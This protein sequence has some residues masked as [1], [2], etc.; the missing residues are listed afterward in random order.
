MTFSHAEDTVSV[1]RGI[2]F[3]PA[4]E[5]TA[6]ALH[7]LPEVERQQLWADMT[8]NPDATQ[9][10]MNGESSELLEDSINALNGIFASFLHCNDEELFAIKLAFQQN[11]RYVNEQKLKFLRA[12]DFD[13]SKAAVRM[14]S[15]FT[16]KLDL[17]GPELLTRDIRQD[18]LSDD[19]LGSLAGGGI[20]LLPSGDHAARGVMFTRAS[21]YVYKERTNMVRTTIC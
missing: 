1:A 8:G 19:D 14:I 17:F 13:P 3:C 4:E 11:A 9:F 2:W 10:R 16:S 20:Q 7:E 5:R 12:D 6:K 15:F 18:D 21:N